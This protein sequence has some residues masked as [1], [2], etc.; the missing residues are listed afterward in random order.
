M[1]YEVE[2]VAPTVTPTDASVT[3]SPVM[4][5]E[6]VVEPYRQR[7]S[8]ITTQPMEQIGQQNTNEVNVT[9][10]AGETQPKPTEETVTLSPQMA[11]L[12]RK[13][14]AFRRQQQEFKAQLAAAQA[15]Q[16]E[17]NELRAM[18]EALASRDF[19]KIQDLVPYN[20]YATWLIENG[21]QTTPEQ[22]A[23]KKL[24]TEL[25][26]VKKSQKDDVEKR[27]EAAV[28]E[29]RTAVKE[30]VESKPEYSSIKELGQQEAVVQHIL[31]TWEHDDVELSVEQAALEVEQA[32]VERG[33]KWA[34]ISKLKGTAKP[35]EKKELPPM[36]SGAKTLTN[37]MTI[38]GEVKSPRRSFQGLTDS[39]RYA[40]ARRRAEEKL[41]QGIR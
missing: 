33:Q 28:A 7:I 32:L 17:L 34:S 11:A 10:T 4:R 19:S 5:E 40:E 25:E 2:A 31:D 21:S 15:Q 8:K 6:R 37:E 9:P 22:Q 30:L 26:G 13:E 16:A 38:Q 14:Q 1:S 24:E 18:K 12:A 23:L 41:K 29:R 36:K 3:S 27:F 20:D 39:E 35:E